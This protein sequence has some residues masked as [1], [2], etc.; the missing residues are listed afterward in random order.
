MQKTSSVSVAT[1]NVYVNIASNIYKLNLEKPA[2]EMNLRVFPLPREINLSLVRY[3]IFS[4]DINY[5]HTYIKGKPL[6]TFSVSK[7]IGFFPWTTI[8]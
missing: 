4:G 1:D 7:V 8:R 6:L 2:P 3:Q 5:T